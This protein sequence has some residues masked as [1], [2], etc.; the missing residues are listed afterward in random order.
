MQRN[1]R[2]RYADNADNSAEKNLPTLSISV[3]R[4]KLLCVK[5]QESDGELWPERTRKAQHH[6]ERTA[7]SIKGD[8]LNDLLI[9][10]THSR[11]PSD[12]EHRSI[13]ILLCCLFLCHPASTGSSSPSLL[14]SSLVT[15][16]LLLSVQPKRLI[17][18]ELPAH[19]KASST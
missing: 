2:E 5:K 10:Y 1:H 15:T 6:S 12:R 4:E 13:T 8:L 17:R 7:N 16:A 18:E 3:G 19:G 14:L 11:R 9:R